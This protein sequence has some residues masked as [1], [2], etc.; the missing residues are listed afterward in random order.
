MVIKD[1]QVVFVNEICKRLTIEDG[2]SKS[3]EM[4]DNKMFKLMKDEEKT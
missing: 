1:E 4:L 2:E 3:S